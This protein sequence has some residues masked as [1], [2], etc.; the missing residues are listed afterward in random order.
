M[1]PLAG[2]WLRY[3]GVRLGSAN[4]R[5]YLEISWSRKQHGCLESR[6]QYN[7][8]DFCPSVFKINAK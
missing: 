3:C 2:D 6:K 4:E 5:R 8:S 7:L 1:E